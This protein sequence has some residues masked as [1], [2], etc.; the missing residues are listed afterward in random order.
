M[1][2]VLQ[3]CTQRSCLAFSR[4]AGTLHCTGSQHAGICAAVE[5]RSEDVCA[6]TAGDTVLGRWRHLDIPINPA[7]RGTDSQTAA[8][9]SDNVG[10]PGRSA[11]LT[12]LVTIPRLAARTMQWLY[13]LLIVSNCD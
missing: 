8:R 10:L 5:D 2:K 6:A 12:R 9:C 4:S 11:G 3:N 1:K 13:W 7:P